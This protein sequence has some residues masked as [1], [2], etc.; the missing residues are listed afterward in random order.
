VDKRALELGEDAAR[1][2]D[3]IANAFDREQ[4]R[5]PNGQ[6]SLQEQDAARELADQLRRMAI[7]GT[8]VSQELAKDYGIDFPC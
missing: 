3:G 6:P 4:I 1:Y 2:Y 5:D 7:K 8:E